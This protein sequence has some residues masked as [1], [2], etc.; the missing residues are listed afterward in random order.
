MGEFGLALPAL[1][2]RLLEDFFGD[3]MAD[4]GLFG[5]Y[6]VL[7]LPA[8][9]TVIRRAV[10]VE[11]WGAPTNAGFD[12]ILVTENVS[13]SQGR[14]ICIEGAINVIPV[15]NDMPSHATLAGV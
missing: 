2:L 6:P 15:I 9:V 11:V 3:A 5:R 4:G 14:L 12:A 8:F 13:F 10:H 1:H 7:G